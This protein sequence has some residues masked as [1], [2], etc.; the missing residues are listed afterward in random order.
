MPEKIVIETKKVSRVFKTGTI[1]VHALTD[2]DLEI[3]EGEFVAIMR[4]ERHLAGLDLGQVQDVV[5][6]DHQ[7]VG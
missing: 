1:E 5:D 7:V 4:Q 2:V 6:D 3:R